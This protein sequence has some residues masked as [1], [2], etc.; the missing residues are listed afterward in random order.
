LPVIRDFLGIDDGSAI[1]EENQ[2]H[3]RLS[4]AAE[5]LGE[6]VTTPTTGILVFHLDDTAE[7]EQR[8]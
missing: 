4:F 8:P 3:R 7:I 1:D 6:I 5:W 2:Q